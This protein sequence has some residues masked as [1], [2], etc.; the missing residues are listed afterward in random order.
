MLLEKANEKAAKVVDEV[1]ETIDQL[2]EY[3]RKYKLFG[4]RLRKSSKYKAEDEPKSIAEAY[5]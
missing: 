3:R 4:P 5:A 1:N 2:R